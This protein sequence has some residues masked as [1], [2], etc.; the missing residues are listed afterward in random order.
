M[1]RVLLWVGGILLGLTSLCIIGVIAIYFF[2][3][4]DTTPR[5]ERTVWIDGPGDSRIRGEIWRSP[6]LWDSD[7]DHRYIQ[8][9]VDGTETPIG[10]GPQALDIARA[11]LY[12]HGDQAELVVMGSVYRLDRSGSWSEFRAEDGTFL[13]RYYAN[14]RSSRPVGSSWYRESSGVSCYIVDLNHIGH[15]LVSDC[16]FPAAARLFFRRASYDDPWILD[17][18]TTFAHSPPPQHAPFP[19]SARGILTVVGVEPAAAGAEL[20]KGSRL[21][22]ALEVAGSRQLA[23]IEFEL[24]GTEPAEVSVVA[25]HF[26][27]EWLA[28]GRWVDDQGW[29]VLFW[30]DRPRV[31]GG[32]TQ[33]LG[34]PW[35]EAWLV[36]SGHR[37]REDVRYLVY[38]E[39]R[40]Q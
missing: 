38:L 40:R 33:R 30:S 28:R 22:S 36:D 17:Q 23:R 1:R 32:Y 13:Y 10:D 16:N 34:Q 14:G 20:L 2:W 37:Y 21:E 11:K 6:G 15:R 35:D 26:E 4:V 9:A 19:E 25:E 39:L 7:I 8:V 12:K 3:S 24:A 18:A 27:E 31:Y 29:P 5:K